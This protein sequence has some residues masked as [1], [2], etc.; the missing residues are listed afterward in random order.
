MSEQTQTVVGSEDRVPGRAKFSSVVQTL[1]FLGIVMFIFVTTFPPFEV[2]TEINLSVHM[3]QH[4]LIALSGVLVSYP[5]YRQGKFSKIA[6][7]RN[8]ILGFLFIAS[9]IIFW[10]LPFAW[11]AAVLNPGTHVIEHLTFFGVGLAIGIFVPMLTDNLKMLVFVLA[12]SG[13]MIYGFVLFIS[14]TPIYP[15]YSLSQQAQL[16]LWLFAPAPIYFI[17]FLY[18]T[19]TSE[20]RKLDKQNDANERIFPSRPSRKLHMIVAFLSIIMIVSLAS[21][22]SYAAAA[23]SLA[24][25]GPSPGVVNIYIVDT[26]IQWN[27][28][29]QDIVVVLGTNS[30]VRWIS[31]SLTLDTVT[32]YTNLFNSGPISQGQSWSY[33]F[34]KPGVYPYHCLY[35][36]W[37]QGKITVLG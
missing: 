16:G 17:G 1:P 34:T 23:I 11:D 2:A 19:L 28:S 33:T 31:H 30:T 10:H 6:S 13:H 24:H 15:L 18:L 35:H 4:V 8:G 7:N 14:T 12:L 37:M 9:A 22:Y 25:Y 32:S 26:P 5:L 3:L 27:Y 20:S 21:Y 29:P 36:S